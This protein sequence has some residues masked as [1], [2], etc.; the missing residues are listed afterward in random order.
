[1]SVGQHVIN[2]R[3]QPA[4][5]RPSKALPA[6]ATQLIQLKV[7]KVFKVRKVKSVRAID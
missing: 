4:V 5:V 6:R 2:R 3:R 7:H 1:L